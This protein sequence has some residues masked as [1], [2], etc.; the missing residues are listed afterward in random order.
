[1]GETAYFLLCVRWIAHFNGF[2]I[3]VEMIAAEIEKYHDSTIDAFL[4]MYEADRYIKLISQALRSISHLRE[5][6]DLF[7]LNHFRIIHLKLRYQNCAFMICQ[8]KEHL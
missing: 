4:K 7:S 5:T 3:V 8:K 6:L 2:I 1:M